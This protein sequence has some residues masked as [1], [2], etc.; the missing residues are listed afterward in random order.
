MVELGKEGFITFTTNCCGGK[1]KRRR[2]LVIYAKDL[3]FISSIQTGFF[4]I[5]K[6]GPYTT[7]R[8]IV[9]YVGRRFWVKTGETLQEEHTF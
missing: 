4:F 9:R 1:H 7:N 3:G 6:T 2:F 8:A 5:V